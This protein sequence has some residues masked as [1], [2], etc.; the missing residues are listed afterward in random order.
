MPATRERTPSA[1]SVAVAADPD[2]GLPV[3]ERW[4]WDPHPDVRWIVRS[5][6]GKAR[7]RRV[8]PGLVAIIAGAA[9]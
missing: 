2:L 6:L 4:L 1:Y 8:A 7:L 3:F 5:N 9:G